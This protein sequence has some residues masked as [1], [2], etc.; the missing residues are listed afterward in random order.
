L[1]V[2][3]SLSARLSETESSL[4]GSSV[5]LRTVIVHH[6]RLSHIVQF[7]GCA[8]QTQILVCS[9]MLSVA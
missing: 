8:Q 6:L 3:L 9:W 2:E 1:K 4:S 5:A 7:I